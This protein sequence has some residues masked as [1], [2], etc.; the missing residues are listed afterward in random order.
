MAWYLAKYSSIGGQNSGIY[1]CR[2]VRGSTRTTSL[3]GEGRAVDL[4]LKYVR[5]EFWELAELLRT[6]SKELG[7]QCIIYDRKIFSGGYSNK[8]WHNYTG[9][10]AHTDHLHVEMSWASARMSADNYVALLEKTL[11]GKVG[12]GTVKPQAS[13]PK[14]VGIGKQPTNYKDVKVDGKLGSESITALQIVLRA[15]D[16]YN[17]EVDGK[18]GYYTWVGL[19]KWMRAVGEYPSS[20][21]VID[22]KAG[23]ETWKAV[24]RFLRKKGY[25]PASK[26]VIDG[27]PG[28]AT[29][30]ALQRYLNTQNVD[31]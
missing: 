6:H 31:K 30:K 3:H 23:K 9:V 2:N 8:G 18:G 15:I 27:D 24:Q 19:Q 17:R 4:G 13:K 22:G 16:C 29:I 7:I 26:Y 28:P 14:P 10:N 20:K 25:Y 5:G 11:G 1:N 21:F 12:S